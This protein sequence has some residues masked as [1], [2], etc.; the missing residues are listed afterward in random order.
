ME[1]EARVVSGWSYSWSVAVLLEFKE[2]NL[3]EVQQANATKS[4]PKSNSFL[5]GQNLID[6]IF[7]PLQLYHKAWPPPL[8]HKT[9]LVILGL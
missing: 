7:S 9:N 1:R 4:S 8:P 5:K 3:W 6:T 2:A